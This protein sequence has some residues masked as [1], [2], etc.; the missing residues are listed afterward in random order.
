MTPDQRTLIRDTKYGGMLEIKCSKLQPEL[1]KLLMQSFDPSSCE[2]VFPSRGSIPANE[3]FV[4]Q[5]LGVPRGKLKV[6]YERDAEATKFMK[7]QLGNGV[8]KQPTI[9]SLKNKLLSIDKVS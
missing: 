9:A 2:M 1:C 6:W 4:E 7:E 8:R 3:V 5:V